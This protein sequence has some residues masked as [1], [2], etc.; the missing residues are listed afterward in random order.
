MRVAFRAVLR[1]VF[2]PSPCQLPVATLEVFDNFTGRTSLLAVGGGGTPD[3][4]D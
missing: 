3:P 2:P 4:S 1:V